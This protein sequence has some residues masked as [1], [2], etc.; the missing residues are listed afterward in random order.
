MRKIIRGLG[1]SCKSVRAWP[2][3][4]TMRE[5]VQVTAIASDIY[6]ADDRPLRA[7]MI[8]ERTL[9]A[10]S[11][12]LT[13]PTDETTHHNA[14][15]VNERISQLITLRQQAELL[16]ERDLHTDAARRIV[17]LARRLGDIEPGIDQLETLASAL[18]ALINTFDFSDVAAHAELA[19]LLRDYI[20][21]E[22]DI[23]NAQNNAPALA[24][25]AITVRYTGEDMLCLGLQ[26]E[27]AALA[28]E[29]EERACVLDEA[30]R[31]EILARI[32]ELRE[33]F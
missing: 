11:T 20:A 1:L 14:S 33:H 7:R 31:S 17:A 16:C 32:A 21:V 26:P 30:N 2:S 22:R 6:D 24:S 12:L 29:V 23:L 18:H 8:R 4:Y 13:E 28:E 27:V 10:L 25:F 5:L 15:D 9:L 19:P 3:S